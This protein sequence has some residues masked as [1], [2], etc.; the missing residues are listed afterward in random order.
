MV[1][2]A[3]LVGAINA[4]VFLRFDYDLSATTHWAPSAATHNAQATE[5]P[6][7]LQAFLT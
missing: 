2:L 4:A 3:A 7:V 6:V 1:G 5:W